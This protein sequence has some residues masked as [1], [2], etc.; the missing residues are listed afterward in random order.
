MISKGQEVSISGF[1][2]FGGIA[3]KV[4]AVP[5]IR[6]S[7]FKLS[8]YSTEVSENRGSLFQVSIMLSGVIIMSL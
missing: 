8:K 4:P 7:G 6:I 2:L 1:K 3:E 5:K